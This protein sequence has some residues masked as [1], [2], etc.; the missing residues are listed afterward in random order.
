M[1]YSALSCHFALY[2]EGKISRFMFENSSNW[3]TTLWT[4]QHAVHKFVTLKF[5]SSQIC[6]PCSMNSITQSQICEPDFRSWQWNFDKFCICWM[7]LLFLDEECW[8]LH[9]FG[10]NLKIGIYLRHFL[11]KN[12][13]IEVSSHVLHSELR[14]KWGSS[15]VHSNMSE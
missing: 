12:R 1:K 3:M 11:Y 14:G 6:P 8:F 7:Y 2:S 13:W 15:W 4:F 5:Q 9:D 10:G